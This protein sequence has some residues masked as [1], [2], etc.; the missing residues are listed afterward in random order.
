MTL[1]ARLMRV[2]LGAC[3]FCCMA[4]VGSGYVWKGFHSIFQN[5]RTSGGRLAPVVEPREETPL[6]S[7]YTRQNAFLG[8][9][10]G[11]GE[12]RT[13]KSALEKV[14][15]DIFGQLNFCLRQ[16]DTVLSGPSRSKVLNEITNEVF[17]AIMIGF[18][19]IVDEV[20]QR[21]DYYRNLT[22]HAPC[23]LDPNEKNPIKSKPTE[24]I[25]IIENCETDLIVAQT[26]IT[27]LED[28]LIRGNTKNSILLGGIYDR[29]YK[30]L[31]TL[32]KDAHCRFPADETIEFRPIPL[33]HNICLSLLDVQFTSTNTPSNNNDNNAAN[34]EVK[35]HSN[36]SF[37]YH[38]PSTKTQV[39]NQISNIVVRCILYGSKKD[40]THIANYIDTVFLL[41]FANNWMKGNMKSQ[42]I[43]YLK[44]LVILL[45]DNLAAAEAAIAFNRDTILKEPSSFFKTKLRE[46]DQSQSN[47]DESIWNR[48]LSDISDEEFLL[49]FE[50]MVVSNYPSTTTIT[51]SPWPS[52]SPSSSNSSIS[53][54]T[55]SVN[56]IEPTAFSNSKVYEYP[57]NEE[58]EADEE[59]QIENLR[60][61]DTYQNAFHRVVEVCLTEIGSQQSS[62]DDINLPQTD[63]FV[64]SFLTWEQALRRNLTVDLWNKNP[65]EL[66]G[67]WELVNVGGRGSLN[68]IMIGSTETL[69]QAV[70][71]VRYL[72]DY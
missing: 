56:V 51:P 42:E 66:S 12:V 9:F 23:V 34:K 18:P 28:L 4:W 10:P 35:E 39:L 59:D 58:E 32:L 67:T 26:Y 55:S 43:L 13:L 25:T 50:D 19:P 29:G 62:V 38:F 65:E 24:N 27:W 22:T 69:F 37:L 33:D 5:R 2:G 30:R 40:R 8:D 16:S 64:Q 49:Y 3:L 21:I 14:E 46:S 36:P 31:L 6:Y 17:K 15:T 44:A 48:E 20:L 7:F 11:N 47:D 68:A 70:D 72:F 45:K 63:E 54:S 60:L 53:S 57:V 1:Y 52:S 41:Q 71:G 61:Y